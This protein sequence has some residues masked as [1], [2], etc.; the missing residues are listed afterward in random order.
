MKEIKLL[1]TFFICLCYS[2]GDT[3]CKYV[4][5]IDNE[6]KYD[7]LLFI[8]SQND[9]EELDSILCPANKETIIDEWNV[10]ATK[11]LNCIEYHSKDYMKIIIK[12][13]SKYL[14]KD[15][16]DDNNWECVGNR[17]FN[18]IGVGNYYFSI[19]NSFIITEDDL[20]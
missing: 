3:V 19:K 14:T 2:C 15:T 13:S 11:Q 18:L 1:V 5:C 7:I 6:T 10:S 4:W 20:E 9:F 17:D 8:P 16:S 12:D